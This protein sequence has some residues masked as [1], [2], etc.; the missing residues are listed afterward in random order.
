MKKTE[1]IQKKIECARVELYRMERN[2]GGLLHPN[3]IKQSMKLD[4]LI[5]KYYCAVYRIEK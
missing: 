2:H 1:V 3:V 5:N 4:E